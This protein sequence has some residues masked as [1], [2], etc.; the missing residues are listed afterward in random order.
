MMAAPSQDHAMYLNELL[1]GIVPVADCDNCLVS[2]LQLD[3]RR[4]ANGDLF[5]ACRGTT[6][7]GVSHV[8][9]ALQRGAAA[10][11]YEPE[12]AN[13]VHPLGVPA[14]AVENLGRYVGEIASRFYGNPSRSL[15]VVGIT[16]TNGKTSCAHY[17]A[18]ALHRPTA[19][20]GVVGTIGTGLYGA[21]EP[22]RNTTPDA[23]AVQSALS[24]F[25]LAG[26]REVVMEVSSHALEQGRVRGVTFSTAVFTNLTHDHLDYH[27][28]M[29]AYEAAKRRLFTWPDLASVVINIDEP[30]GRRLASDVALTVNSVVYGLNAEAVRA[31]EDQP[32]GG[33]SR[34]LWAHAG[35]V[36]PNGSHIGV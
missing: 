8:A 11:I 25:H 9:E 27:G 7:H 19:P 10:V 4:I 13:G 28:D 18:Q 24:R 14:I 16:G 30:A 22:S 33:A 1:Q 36:N 12:G 6:V 32:T 34:H 3:S 15:R 35:R 20:C 2:G 17:L 31:P 23:V 5:I 29:A 21:L 26:A